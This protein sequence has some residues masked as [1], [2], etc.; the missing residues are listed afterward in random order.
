MSR[1]RQRKAKC[2]HKTPHLAVNT[3]V[4]AEH[5]TAARDPQS[6]LGS[7]NS[8]LLASSVYG[9]VTTDTTEMSPMGLRS[10]HSLAHCVGAART[11]RATASRPPTRRAWV[12]AVKSPVTSVYKRHALSFGVP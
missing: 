5:I 1:L 3:I 12:T 4:H 7:G 9:L 11:V 6:T 2:A 10:R 8:S